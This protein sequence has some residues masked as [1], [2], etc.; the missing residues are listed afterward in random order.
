M[1]AASIY[2]LSQP[3]FGSLI[4][5]RLIADRAKNQSA[6]AIAITGKDCA[7]KTT[8]AANVK[9]A[10]EKLGAEAQVV[11]VDDFII[12]LE[13]RTTDPSPAQEYLLHTF[14]ADAYAHTVEAACR[15]ADVSGGMVV[16]E[17]V[18]LLRQDLRHLWDVSVW[19]EVDETTLLRRATARDAAWFGG[20][21]AVNEAY[22]NRFLPAQRLHMS[23]DCPCDHADV[24]ARFVDGSWHVTMVKPSHV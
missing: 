1:S 11:T 21:D 12:P 19:L 16:A 14:D 5:S 6:V 13:R 24:F 15:D 4:A 2:R 10:A 17:G 8:L 20:A 18:F 9:F 3:Q 7:G 22:I 23:R